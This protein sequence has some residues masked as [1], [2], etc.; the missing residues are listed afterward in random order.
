MSGVADMPGE[1]LRRN[2]TAVLDFLAERGI[3]DVR[4]FGSV[5]RSRDVAPSDIDLL[6]KLPGERSAG[7]E[8]LA[9]LELS[10]E[11]SALLGVRVDVATARALR[12]EVRETALAEAVPL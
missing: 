9:V 2:R 6:V 7:G 3:H 5:A 8:L 11:L 12:P 1:L 4:V 10:E